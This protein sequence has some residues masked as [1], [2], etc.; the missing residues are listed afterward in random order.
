M[1]R[2]LDAMRTHQPVV[3]GL[4]DDHLTRALVAAAFFTVAMF[5]AT[6][7]AFLIDARTIDGESVWLKPQ[8]FNI[9]LAVHFLTLA[10][11]AQQAPR[12]VR[13]GPTLSLFAYAAIVSMAFEVIYMSIQAA[14]ARRSHFNYETA[15]ESQ[16]Y[17]AMGLGALFLVIVALV[18]AVQIWRKG[19]RESRGLR[20]GSILG[21]IL[22]AAATIAFAGYMSA[23]GSHFVGAHPDGGAKA[24]FFGWSLETGDLRPA[25][26]AALHAMQTLPAIG[27]AVDRL[28]GPSRL[29]VLVAAAAQIGLAAALF[30]QALQGR[31][32]W[33]F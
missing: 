33:P 3:P 24:P 10:I 5:V 26:F 8:K 29:A 11:L 4:D 16:L 25:H 1:R 17:M 15:L 9:S 19:Q 7:P 14:R 6:T 13:A 31:P 23:S 27:F 32:F 22:G 30:F 21:L 28:G 2:F 12:R 20:L 18:L